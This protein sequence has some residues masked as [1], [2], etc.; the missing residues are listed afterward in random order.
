MHPVETAAGRDEQQNENMTL[1]FQYFQPM[2]QW[3]MY[4]TNEDDLVLITK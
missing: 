2:K 1:F 4:T 3:L